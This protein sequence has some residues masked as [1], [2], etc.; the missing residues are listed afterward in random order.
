MVVIRIPK[1]ST[2]NCTAEA[3]RSFRSALKDGTVDFIAVKIARSQVRP[4]KIARYN[5]ARLQDRVF[6]DTCMSRI[7]SGDVFAVGTLR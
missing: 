7:L 4:K 5:S 6:A 3:P 1:H 2:A